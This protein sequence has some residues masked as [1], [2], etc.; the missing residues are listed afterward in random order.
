M[1]ILFPAQPGPLFSEEQVILRCL[2]ERFQEGAAYGTLNTLRSAISLINDS[3]LSKSLLLNRFFKGIFKLRPALPKYQSIWDVELVFKSIEAWGPLEALNLRKLSFKLVM[4]LALGSAFRVQSLA[5]IK[6]ENIKEIRDG[7]E[8][9]IDDLIKTSRPGAP[10]QYC[11]FPLFNE[12]T[13]LCITRTI[14]HYIQVTKDLRKN[15]E[16]LFIS[17][18]KPHRVVGSQTISRWLKTVLLEAGIGKTYTAHSTRHASTSKA[19]INGMDINKI[20]AAA[21]WSEGSQTF[22]RFYNRPIKSQKSSF[23]EAV[24]S[25]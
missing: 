1:E 11:F 16:R 5:L 22:A 21:G 24:F 14:L 9:I 13:T 23:A 2:T 19:L 25:I 18:Q 17:F 20:K 10:P 15:V 4:L 12:R 7:V 6:L 8:I 3:D